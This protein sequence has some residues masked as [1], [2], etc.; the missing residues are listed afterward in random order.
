[1]TPQAHTTSDDTQKEMVRLVE[2]DYERTAQFI[3]GIISTTATI[4]GWAVTIW[5]AIIGVAVDR[6]QGLLALVAAVVVFA[7]LL[8]DGYHAW[9]YREA[10]IHATA[11]ER[12]SGRYYDS[13]GR[14]LDDEDIELDLRVALESHRFGMY[15]NL[16]QFRLN[17]LRFVRPAIFFQVFYPMLVVLAVVVAGLL[18]GAGESKHTTCEVF[19]QEPTVRVECGDVIVTELPQPSV[20]GATQVPSDTPSIAPTKPAGSKA[21]PSASPSPSAAQ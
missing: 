18:F 7:F 1:M 10:L 11:L 15:R 16:K 8:I 5:L 21:V 17:D 12:L 13:L 6:G 3:N 19:L 9:L 14:G 4:R 2:L 20:P